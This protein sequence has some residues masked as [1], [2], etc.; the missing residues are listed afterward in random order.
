MFSSVRAIHAGQLAVS[1]GREAH[2]LFEG[3]DELAGAVVAAAGGHLVDGETA[4]AAEQL[5]GPLDAHA[6][7]IGGEGHA[8]ELLEIA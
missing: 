2:Q 5:A 3:G 6:I 7:Q 4:F 1:A 8:G